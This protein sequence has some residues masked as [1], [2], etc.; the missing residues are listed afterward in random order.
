M[1]GVDLLIYITKLIFVCLYLKQNAHVGRV[2]SFIIITLGK[3]ECGYV[4]F[5]S[6]RT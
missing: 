6:Y 3:V 5:G 2:V 4:K 1:I